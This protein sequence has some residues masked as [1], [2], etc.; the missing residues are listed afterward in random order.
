M[1]CNQCGNWNEADARFCIHCGAKIESAAF[2]A[3]ACSQCGA[4]LD[5]NA[6]F[7]SRCGAKTQGSRVAA[8]RE[9]ARRATKRKSRSIL[10]I[11]AG[12]GVAIAVAAAVIV[13]QQSDQT[14]AAVPAQTEAAGAIDEPEETLSAD[15]PV[16]PTLEL[17]PATTEAPTLAPT[18]APTEAPTPAPTPAPTEQ[19]TEEPAAVDA[20]EADFYGEWI[21]TKYVQELG[22]K[23]N[24]GAAEG[25]VY[26]IILSADKP[27]QYGGLV[28]DEPPMLDEY[29]CEMDTLR[30][31][32]WI[33]GLSAA[34]IETAPPYG[35]SASMRY[36]IDEQGRL[37]ECPWTNGRIDGWV[38]IYEKQP[39][40]TVQGYIDAMKN[41]G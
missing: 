10:V 6:A 18:P 34:Y 41:G 9:D 2:S 16:E 24:G 22:G 25:E 13:M 4:R 30:E 36:H 35:D 33:D 8:D 21:L 29:P 7:C 31:D 5:A 40:G 1:N 14:Q 27:M 39:D 11:A 12:V 23:E 3:S 19:P 17:T 26:Y 28:Y 20:A 37:M 38:F 32:L 15:E